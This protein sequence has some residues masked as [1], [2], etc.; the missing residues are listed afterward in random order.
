MRSSLMV[1]VSTLLWASPGCMTSENGLCSPGEPEATFDPAMLGEWIDSRPQEKGTEG[2]YKVERDDPASKAYRVTAIS[3]DADG[4]QTAKPLVMKVYLTKFGD[5]H[6][7]DVICPPEPGRQEEG[8]SHFIWKVKIKMPEVT[9]RL[10]SQDYVKVH[11]GEIRHT[12]K[13]SPLGGQS[14]R[15]IAT[16]GELRE[17][18]RGHDHDDAAWERPWVFLRRH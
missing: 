14:M 4:K 3:E 17:F 12:V 2:Y 18:V 8:P 13:I 16:P 7:L 10:L 15:L 5:S 9:L 6:F 11:P 1:L